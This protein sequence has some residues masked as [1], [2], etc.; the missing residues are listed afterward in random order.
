MTLVA[1]LMVMGTTGT[2]QATNEGNEQVCTGL[3][4]GKIDV[5]DPPSVTVTAPEGQLISGYCVKAG[6]THNDFGP[7]YVVL[8]EPVE[9]L[10]ITYPGKDSI[11]HYSVSYVDI[12][13]ECPD[14]DGDQ[15]EGTDCDV[16]AVNPGVDLSEEC[17]VEGTYTIPDTEGVQYLLDG[18]DIGPG[19]Y[20]GPVSGTVTAEASGEIPLSN[21]GFSFA[22]DVPAAED[23]PDIAAAETPEV[24][25]SAE[26]DVE[27]TFTIPDTAG[28]QYLVDGNPVAS[29][30][31]DGP[32]SATVTAVGVGET[33]LEDPEW[34]Y[35]LLVE[36]AEVC[37]VLGEESEKPTPKP[38]DEP[39]VKGT[40]AVPSAVDAG[41]VGPVSPVAA[42]ESVL[43]QGLV[44]GGLM[45]LLLA[46]W[47]QRGRLSRG[48]HQF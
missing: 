28:V 46:G 42:P 8:D 16:T 31:Y 2:A 15:P 22:L 18:A 14:L 20:D 30:T 26:C 3:D 35:A 39:T 44:V 21:P 1:G 23:C 40:E 47:L 25:Q 33:V 38:D 34:E 17:E 5:N 41:F 12:H 19:T 4:S 7:V 43:G 10:T 6:S 37:E 24:D 45:L 9:T 11:S 48:A 29:G 13:D 27:G 36:E 32:I